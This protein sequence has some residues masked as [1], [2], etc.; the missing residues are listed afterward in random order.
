VS[1]I[2]KWQ[3]GD[4]KLLPIAATRQAGTLKRLKRGAVKE[5]DEVSAAILTGD[6]NLPRAAHY[7]IVRV[8]YVVEAARQPVP[9]S[10]GMGV[11]V[12]TDGVAHVT[13]FV[14]SSGTATSELA[15]LLISPTP[16]KQLI[17]T[18]GAAE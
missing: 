1:A 4:Y 5:V 3:T 2:H 16:I 8:G 14:L 18:C 9:A 15:A 7:Y 13:S 6:A 11:D 17:S 12:N 10:L